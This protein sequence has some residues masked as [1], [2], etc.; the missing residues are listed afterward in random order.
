MY[1]PND[2]YTDGCVLLK[3]VVVL[4]YPAH[5]FS[6]SCNCLQSQSSRFVIEFG[7]I[8]DISP[9]E[10]GGIEV[11]VHSDLLSISAFTVSMGHALRSTRLDLHHSLPTRDQRRADLLPCLCLACKGMPCN[12]FCRHNLCETDI[13][14]SFTAFK[15]KNVSDVL[16]I[17]VSE[18]VRTKLIYSCRHLVVHWRGTRRPG[19]QL[20]V[21]T[22][23]GSPSSCIGQVLR[24]N[25]AEGCY[26]FQERSIT[27]RPDLSSK[28]G[29]LN[30]EWCMH[31]VSR[32]LSQS[33][34]L[35]ARDPRSQ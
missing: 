19:E 10:C 32:V 9:D 25:S 26:V 30:I 27:H 33:L 5:G 7:R 21:E 31:I 15:S 1:G 12:S 18:S 35:I 13:F 16:R 2:R 6:R 29:V 4:T 8:D 24:L 3:V 11:S 28:H 23:A 22:R 34:R 17:D 14:R 20:K